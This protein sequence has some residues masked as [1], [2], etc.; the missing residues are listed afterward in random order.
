[1]KITIVL[2]CLVF[3]TACTEIEQKEGIFVAEV[4]D[5]DTFKLN[6]GERVRLI[7]IDAPERYEEFYT[8]STNALFA[9][10]FYKQVILERDITDEDKYNRSL[11]YVFVN[12]TFVNLEMVQEGYAKSFP[13]EP[14]TK[15][16]EELNKAQEEAI[17][18]RRGMWIF[19]EETKEGIYDPICIELGCA[20]GDFF[21]GSRNSD[22]YHDCGSYYARR[23]NRENIV[24]FKSKLHAESLRYYPSS[25]VR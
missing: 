12:N 19:L 25:S 7:G 4:I 21:V 20:K 18:N 17:E 15:Y 5:G 16:Q 3:I 9:L 10:I 2:L 23:I 6:T 8:E 24:C 1:M 11:R 22:K 14:D 13:Y